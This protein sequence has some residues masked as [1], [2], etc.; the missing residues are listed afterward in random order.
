MVHD[1]VPVAND[2]HAIHIPVLSFA[3][4]NVQFGEDIAVDT[5]RFL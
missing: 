1:E 3:N 4:S 5:L 2:Q